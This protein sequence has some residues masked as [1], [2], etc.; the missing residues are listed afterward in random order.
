MRLR[1]MA[2]RSI[3]CE[4]ESF[5]DDQTPSSQQQQWQTTSTSRDRS[6]R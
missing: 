6:T 1:P 3:F 4:S 2:A 5:G